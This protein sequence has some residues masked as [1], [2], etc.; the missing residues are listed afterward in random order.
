MIP[1]LSRESH[2]PPIDGSRVRACDCFRFSLLGATVNSLRPL[3]DR[4]SAVRVDFDE[5][6]D[7]DAAFW[8]GSH[9]LGHF[10]GL[11]PTATIRRR[12][13]TGRKK[14]RN[15]PV[16]SR[17]RGVGGFG[18][19]GGSGA[20]AVAELLGD[21]GLG[22]ERDL[23]G[24]VSHRKTQEYRDDRSDGVFPHYLRRLLG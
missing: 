13:A 7:L 16:R 3:A 2:I 23:I 11:L 18:A 1:N 15:S 4:M 5:D 8:F 14:T 17:D 21:P 24:N 9:Q 12:D 22:Q 19:A 20:A 6:L 10:R